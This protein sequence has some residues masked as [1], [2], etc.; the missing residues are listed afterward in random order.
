MRK[1]YPLSI[2][3]LLTVLAMLFWSF[4]FIWVAQLYQLG[5]RPI[6]VVFLRLVVA[7]VVLVAVTRLLRINDVIQKK[8]YK[9]IFFLAFAEPFCYFLGESFGMLYVTPTLASIIV[10][11]IPLVTPIFAWMLLRERVNVYEIV[12]LLVSFLGVLILVVEDL[13]LGGKVIGVLLMIVAVLSG[14]AYGIIL[15]KLAD[16]YPALTITKY[17]TFIGMLLFLPLFYIFEFRHFT[18]MTIDLSSFKYI[19]L[20]GILPSSLS[21]TFLAIAV[22]RLGVVRTN[23]FSNLIPVFVGI[24]AFYVLKEAFS[25][26]KITAMCV[27]VLGLFVSQLNKIRIRSYLIFLFLFIFQALFAF[28]VTT[29]DFRLP[30]STPSPTEAAM[31]GLNVASAD[32]LYLI[33]S[34]PSLMRQLSKNA[35][36]A[37]SF[38]VPPNH[39]KEFSDIIKTAPPLKKNTL[40]AIA[41][42]TK[43]IGLGYQALAEDSFSEDNVYQDYN[44]NSWVLAISDSVGRVNWGFSA[45]LLTGRIVYLS[46]F[47]PSQP[48]LNPLQLGGES[49]S[50]SGEGDITFIDSKALGYSFDLGLS[51]RLGAFSYGLVAYDVFSSINWKDYEK[52]KIKTRIGFG[53]DFSSGNWRYG[54]GS[55]TRWGWKEN[56]LYNAYA[57]YRFAIGRPDLL[58]T[59]TLSFS[60]VSDS[61][62]SQDDTL[63]NFGFGY[64]YKVVRL[65]VS[66]QTKGWKSNETQYL[67]SLGFGE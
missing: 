15:K 36:I 24:M 67:F 3:Y 23:I 20:L 22:R 10:S 26:L 57:V 38:A 37:V 9:L 53:V 6:G 44:L 55:N 7:S 48:P 28:P 35:N 49:R 45:K 62:K 33:F 31:G 34:N 32:D 39:Y 8:D 16:N 19:L 50:P 17:Q 14:T 25:G 4:A 11:T 60:V 29:Y 54:V 63:F 46:Q 61:F 1:E 51:S 47:P 58:Q 59:S 43:Q 40:R 56:P 65:D 41:F 13:N 27:V 30:T 66:L 12:G 18:E 52:Y 42:Q 64:F 2:V 5:Y 21:F